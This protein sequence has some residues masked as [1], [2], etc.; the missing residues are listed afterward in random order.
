MFG[1]G[2]DEPVYRAMNVVIGTLFV[3]MKKEK[4]RKRRLDLR[5]SIFADKMRARS[6]LMR[7]QLAQSGFAVNEVT[8]DFLY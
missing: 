4:R 1:S 7:V 8:S 5:I 3:T 2:L 6:W